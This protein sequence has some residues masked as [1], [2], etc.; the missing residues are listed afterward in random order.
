MTIQVLTLFFGIES[1]MARTIEFNREEVLENAMHTFW[2]KGYSNTSIPN[3]V[4]ATRLNPGS[5]YAAFDSKEGLFLETL[6]FYGQ[7]SLK[8]LKQFIVD[9]KSPIDGIENFFTVLIDKTQDKD[10]CGCLL[11]NTILEMSSHNSVIKDLANKQLKANETE[12][13]KALDKAKTSRELS[14]NINTQAL[15]KYLMVNIWGLRVL[16]KTG[17]MIGQEQHKDEVLKQI[18]SEL[19]Q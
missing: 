18:M 2:K 3:L 11:V 16:A 4:T 7:R 9:A 6:N 8:S 14:A 19:K 17:T 12:L 13:K 15:A 5:I 1:N 10:H